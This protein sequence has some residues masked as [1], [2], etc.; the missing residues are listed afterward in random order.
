MIERRSTEHCGKHVYMPWCQAC[1]NDKCTRY[2]ARSLEFGW[3]TY[4]DSVIR[5][6]EEDQWLALEPQRLDDRLKD[7]QAGR[8]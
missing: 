1:G 3:C 8:W 6:T 4:H 7:V 2:D 5:M